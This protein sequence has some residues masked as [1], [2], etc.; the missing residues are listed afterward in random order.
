MEKKTFDVANISTS[1]GLLEVDSRYFRYHEKY[2]DVEVEEIEKG[3]FTVK[4]Y[5]PKLNWN[6]DGLMTCDVDL[7]S[8]TESSTKMTKPWFGKPKKVLIQGL[9]EYKKRKLVSFTTNKILII[10]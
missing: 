2:Y 10:E 1:D 6:I 7:D 3:L 4:G 8:V 9:I 5:K